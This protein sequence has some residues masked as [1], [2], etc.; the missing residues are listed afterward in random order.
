MFEMKNLN[1]LCDINIGK[2]PSRSNTL[3]WGEGEKWIAIADLKNKYISDTKEQITTLAIKECNMK[4]IPTN[5]VIMSFKLSLG[6]LSITESPMYSNEAIASFPIKNDQE[7]L[8]E[9]LYYALKT[10]DLKSYA[11]KAVKGITLNK[12]KLNNIKIPYIDIEY[13]QK[14]IK[15][16]KLSERILN[17][18]QSQITALDE[19]T[20]SVFVE[21]FGNPNKPGRY[22]KLPLSEFGEIITGNTPP[23]KE[24]DNYGEFIEWIKSDNINTPSAYLTKAEEC[25]SE[26]GMKKGRVVPKNSI[27]VTC[28]AGSKSC[29]GNA[30]IADR[31]VAFNQQIN[32]IIPSG[33]PYFLYI[34][35]LVGK[36]LIQ[37]ASTNGM[38]GLVSKGVFK[39]VEF[40]Y[41]PQ[42]EQKKF[43]DIFLKIEEQKKLLENSLK[44][45]KDL[46]NSILQRA[47][48]GELFQEQA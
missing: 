27:L 6:K 23:R 33:D 11:D 42:E 24:K 20:Q 38:K 4:V 45:M 17:N 10:I 40:I 29:I 37:K 31:S 14:I 21:R 30:A 47:F 32:A 12:K 13:Q 2:T 15:V 26:K 16:L 9:Y 44:E 19:L 28:I 8:P 1:D 34:Q 39:N 35:F 5:T 46:Y 3:Y 18:R 7:M 22:S 48:R 41:P 43:G 36:S 25:L